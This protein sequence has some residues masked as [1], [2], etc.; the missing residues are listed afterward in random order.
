[1]T[2]HASGGF[3]ST[4]NIVELILP[5]VLGILAAGM[6]IAAYK[7]IGMSQLLLSFRTTKTRMAQHGIR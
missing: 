6:R 1:M 5:L 4:R 2:K 7:R 3:L